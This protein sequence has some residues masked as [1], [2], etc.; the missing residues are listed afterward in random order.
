MSGV[1]QGSVLGPA[2]FNI[3]VSDMDSGT[4]CSLSKVA[5]NTRLYGVVDTLEGSDAI[6]WD[7][8]RLEKWAHANLVKFNKAKCKVLRLGWGNPKHSYRLGGERI[9]SSL[10]EKDLRVLVDEKLNMTDTSVCAHSPEGQP[11][12]GLHPQQHGQ[13]VKGGD[14]V[15]LLCSSETL[16]GVLHLALEPSVWERHGAVG[17]GPE[18]AAKM[19]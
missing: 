13:Q 19:I 17:A 10:E 11:Y 16:P 5:D 6:Q 2:L 7:L 3:F 18:E 4:E 12:S 8:D 14:S 1:P 15:P 9:E